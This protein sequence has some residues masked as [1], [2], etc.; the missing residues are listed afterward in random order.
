MP[1]ATEPEATLIDTSA[2]LPFVSDHYGFTMAYPPDWS[3]H[4]GRGDWTFPDDTAWP[5]GVEVSDWFYFE[6]PDDGSVAASAWWAELEPGQSADQWFLD[7]CA[8]EVTPCDGDE[9]WVPATLD[10]HEGRLVRASDPLAYFG[11]GER[12][13]MLAVW[14]PEDIPALEP[15][16]GGARLLEALVSTVRLPPDEPPTSSPQTGSIDSWLD[17]STWSTDV[18]ERY[19]FTIDHP[20]DWTVIE[21]AH[22]WN[23]ATDS[24]DWDSGGA[25]VF[26]PPDDT[27]SIYLSAWS[28]DVAP[29]TTLGEWAQ[30][31]C[32]QYV[33]SCADVERIAEPAFA[34]AGAREGILLPWDD[35]MVT[36]FPD[37]YDA[38]ATVSIWEQPAPTDARIHIVESGR[39]DSGPYHAR[40]LLE[41]FAA[42]LCIDCTG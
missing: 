40:E 28:V 34:S 31:F 30:A 11:I 3:A 7:Y 26:V 12:I 39:P 6:P 38:A 22:D 23:Q 8:V 21:S 18:S 19:G 16:G 33:S 20:A 4:Q 32:D 41:R 24:I 10:G 14:Q 5:D 27:L 17:T 42:S 1:A 15:Y 9:T 36:F 37:W 25:E 13:Y 2:W 29:M 35:G